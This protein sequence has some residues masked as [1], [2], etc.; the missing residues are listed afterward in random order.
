MNN[1]NNNSNSTNKYIVAKR[2]RVRR[3]QSVTLPHFINTIKYY[4]A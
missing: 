4:N 1:I 3:I 2:R